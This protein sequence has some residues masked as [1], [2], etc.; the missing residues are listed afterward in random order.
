MTGLYTGIARPSVR[1]LGI[2]EDPINGRYADPRA[3]CDF[4]ALQAFGIE[5]DYFGGPGAC[6][7]LPAFVLPSCFALATPS[8]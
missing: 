4:G 8:R 6:R 1:L 3:P 7:W 2:G 5:L